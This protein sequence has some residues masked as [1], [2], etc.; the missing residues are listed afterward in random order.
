MSTVFVPYPDENPVPPESP[1]NYLCYGILT[2]YI[3]DY[4]KCYRKRNHNEKVKELVHKLN[5]T[6]INRLCIIIRKEAE[7]LD[8]FK[9]SEW[10]VG[11]TTKKKYIAFFVKHDIPLIY[12]EQAENKQRCIEF[13]KCDL[14]RTIDKNKNGSY[15]I[16]LKANKSSI[17]C[18][19]VDTIYESS[20]RDYKPVWH[21]FLIYNKK[22]YIKKISKWRCNKIGSFTKKMGESRLRY[23]AE[24]NKRRGFWL[25]NTVLNKYKP[26]DKWWDQ[27]IDVW[28]IETPSYIYID[29]ANKVEGWKIIQEEI[30][31]LLLK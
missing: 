29:D 18:I 22:I 26:P 23:I 2:E 3:V 15:G 4:V 16:I 11:G 12:L 25:N 20:V 24:S 27:E 1:L 9:Y 10:T 21:N 19:M 8:T 14:I 17:E 5:N 13:K 28:N 7:Y 30:K 6:N 31:K